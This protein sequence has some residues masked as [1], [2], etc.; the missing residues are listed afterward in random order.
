MNFC[1]NCGVKLVGGE[2][3]CSNCGSDLS[4]VS[5]DQSSNLE[6]ENDSAI[7]NNQSN[8]DSD[9][10]FSSKII[11]GGS[12][13]RPDKL[14]ITATHVIYQ[15]RNKNLIGNNSISIPINR[16]SSV[17]LN[18][19]L[20]D[21]EITIY[22]TGNKEVVIKDFSIRDAREIKQIIESRIS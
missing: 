9:Y 5:S 11:L 21:A 18:R 6:R 4:V 19:K 12:L 7:E 10:E 22:S 17:K 1:F 14:K 3:F 20:I 13:L 15:K 2:K 8:V 16:I